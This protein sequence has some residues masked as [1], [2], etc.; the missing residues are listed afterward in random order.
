MSSAA[1]NIHGYPQPV[2]QYFTNTPRVGTFDVTCSGFV[3]GRACT[4]ATHAVLELSLLIRQ[5]HVADA[6]FRAYGCPTTIAVGAWLAQWCVGR[7][8]Q[9]LASLCAVELSQALE[10]DE[11][12]TH[13]ALMGEDVVQALIVHIKSEVNI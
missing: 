9:E 12:R 5:E 13:C 10:I 4:P 7:D 8:I 1:A 2:W 3:Q 11:N 6:R